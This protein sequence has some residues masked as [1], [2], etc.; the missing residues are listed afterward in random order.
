MAYVKTNWVNGLTPVN[1]TNLNKIE[2]GIDEAHQ[3]IATKA[4]LTRTLTAGN[5]LTGGGDLTVNRTFTLGTPTTVTGATTNSVTA[6]SHTHALTVTK[7]NVGLGNVDNVQQ[8]PKTFRGQL[9]V[10]NASWVV[11]T[12]GTYTHRREVAITGVVATDTPLVFF[13]LA[14]KQIA[15]VSNISHVESY[16]GGIYL[17]SNGVPSGSVTFDY[18]ILKGV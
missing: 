7:T 1:S 12:Y 17:Y 8:E 10:T 6:E 2:V 9:T 16:A 11:G 3:D 5:G 14:T 4:P 13:T 15:Q 18:R